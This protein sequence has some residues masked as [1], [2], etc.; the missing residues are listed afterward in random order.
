GKIFI[1]TPE[2]KCYAI[3][4]RTG[5]TV[6]ETEG[7]RES[8][9]LSEDGQQVYVKTMF[10]SLYAFH[11]VPDKAISKWRVAGG[12]GYEIG[13]SPITSQ[14]GLVFV[15]SAKGVLYAYDKDDGSA[16]WHIRLSDGLI[17]YA[18]PIGASKLLIS[19]LDG[20]VYLI[21]YKNDGLQ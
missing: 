12:F 8:I 17:N 5:K 19:T 20:Q 16:R 9:G 10:D 7:G 21:G 6:W 15:P 2:R 4:A 18:Q 1:T 13:P 11:T 14:D 3:D